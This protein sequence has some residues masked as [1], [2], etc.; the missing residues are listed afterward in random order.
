MKKAIGIMVIISV[1]GGLLLSENFERAE[2]KVVSYNAQAMSIEDNG[3]V[4][5]LGRYSIQ[6]DA[7]FFDYT[8]S[9]ME[10]S[11]TGTKCVVSFCSDFLSAPDKH[12]VV[13][14]FINNDESESMRLEMTREECEYTIYESEQTT[15][16]VIRLEKLSEA[17]QGTIGIK[18]I[19]VYGQEPTITATKPKEKL[20]WFI[21][22]SITCG[23][24]NETNA[25]EEFVTIKENGNMTYG[26]IAARNLQAD[27]EFIS[28]SGIGLVWGTSEE[29]IPMTEM[30]LYSGYTR[31][32]RSSEFWEINR[33]PDVICVHLGTNDSKYMDTEERKEMFCETYVD[34]MKQLR[35]EHKDTLL[36][37]LYGPMRIEYCD[38]IE[39]CVARYKGETRDANCEILIFDETLCVGSGCGG[40]PT[41]E[42][43]KNM[44]EKL[45]G[46]L[47]KKL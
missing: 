39:D 27:V 4:R 45:T 3:L 32:D 28:Y 8:L 5:M 12:A 29:L 46:L 37:V 7:I 31:G 21:G 6:D 22:D 35:R 23:M 20:F 36:V 43:H 19:E 10:F 41:V 40:H 30:Y 47:E 15:T 1:L 24:G 34:F 14:I 17:K 18:Q 25:T 42:T 33:E 26:A 11:F 44:G 38:V 2:R 9:G 13:G 16:A